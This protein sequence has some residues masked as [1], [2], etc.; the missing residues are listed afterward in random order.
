M[1]CFT[2]PE[3]EAVGICRRCGKGVCRTCASDGPYG[4]TCSGPCGTARVVASRAP[5]IEFRATLKKLRRHAAAMVVAG[6]AIL[7]IGL[8]L[9]PERLERAAGWSAGVFLASGWL[10]YQIAQV[11]G[12]RAEA[13]DATDRTARDGRQ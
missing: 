7:A 11:F 5:A 6:V 3:V 10:F 13:A 2:D 1:R 12:I 4:L 8:W 9:A